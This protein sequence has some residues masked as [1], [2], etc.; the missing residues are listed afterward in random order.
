M[1]GVEELAP[2]AG[3]QPLPRWARGHHRYTEDRVPHI[4][5]LSQRQ[6]AGRA[7]TRCHVRYSFGPDL[8]AEVTFSATTCPTA[9]DLASLL[10]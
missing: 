8:P 2:T 9:P 4:Q 1:R 7:F 3:S 5:A 10:R 6:G